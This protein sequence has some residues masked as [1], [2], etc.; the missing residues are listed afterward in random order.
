MTAPTV[1]IAFRMPAA[2]LQPYISTY[3]E[4]KIEGDEELEDHLHPEWSNIRMALDK[5]WAMGRNATGEAIRLPYL[6]ALHG[7]TSDTTYIRG[8]GRSFGIGILPPGWNR[9]WQVDAS[10][11]ADRVAP[12]TDL[13][14]ETVGAEFEA[15]IRDAADLDSRKSITDA[16]LIQRISRAK[17]N[18]LS[19]QID[20]LFQV[21]AD[22]ANATVEQLTSTLGLPQARLARLSKRGFGF[23]PKLLLRRQRFLRMLGTLHARPYSEWRDFIDPQYSDQSHMVRDFKYFLG[24]SPRA[25]FN[26]DRPIMAA[27][28]VARAAMFGQP[29]QGLH[30][31]NKATA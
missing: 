10:R 11:Y 13:L 18:D 6:S 26:M 8:N 5:P 17:P 1:T 22:P 30:L 9:L 4:L 31:P 12:L 15:A 29:L 24:M 28:T 25:Y 19:T 23:P 7:P 20:S 2:A 3:Y 16:F 14:G 21:L 27:A